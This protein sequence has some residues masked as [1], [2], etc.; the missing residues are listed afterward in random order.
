MSI[1]SLVTGISTAAVCV[2]PSRVADAVRSLKAANSSIPVASGM[3]TPGTTV[4]QH[5]LQCVFVRHPVLCAH[6]WRP[7]SRPARRRWRAACRKSAL[8]W[9]TEPQRSTLSSTGC[10]LSQG[11]GKVRRE[12]DSWLMPLAFPDQISDSTEKFQEIPVSFLLFK[13]LKCKRLMDLLILSSFIIHSLLYPIPMRPDC[14]NSVIA[15]FEGDQPFSLRVFLL[16]KETVE[17]TP[18]KCNIRRN[19]Q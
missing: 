18:S 2:Y 13:T 8:R 14:L 3:T 4:D 15:A 10:W 17:E 11:S 9:T 19:L 5:K 1:P 16:L 12:E 7:A 6:Q